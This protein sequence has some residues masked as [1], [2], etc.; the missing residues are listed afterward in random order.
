MEAATAAKEVDLEAGLVADLEEVMVAA[1]E[2]AKAEDLVEAA[3]A[4]KEVDSEGAR[5]VDSEAGLVAESTHQLYP[6]ALQFLEVSLKWLRRNHAISERRRSDHCLCRCKAFRE[7][8]R[9]DTKTRTTL[10]RT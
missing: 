7:C 10:W 5:E 1:K 3:A 4:A 6:R 8:E 9:R 2:V